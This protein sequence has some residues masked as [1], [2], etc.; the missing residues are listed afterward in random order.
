MTLEVEDDEANDVGAFRP[1]RSSALAIAVACAAPAREEGGLD[2]TRP[3]GSRRPRRSSR[4]TRS[5][6]PISASS[7]CTRPTRWTPILGGARLTPSDAYRLREGRGSGSKWRQAPDQP[8]ARLGGG[9]GSHAEYIGEMYSTLNDG[10]QGS[11]N[12]QI[13][14]SARA[15]RLEGARS[16]VPGIRDKAEPRHA[17]PIRPSTP[18]RR[19]PRAAGSSPG[20]RRSALQAGRVHHHP[21]FE[22]SGAPNGGNLHRNV[23]FRDT[24][25]PELR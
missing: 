22:W 8:A 4:T 10:V 5:R 14:E 24:S 21:A 2:D 13:K 3:A 11:D 18:A 6:K 20:R 19:P 17:P 25:V 23:F 9:H 7:T 12:P 15:H 16:V 1:S